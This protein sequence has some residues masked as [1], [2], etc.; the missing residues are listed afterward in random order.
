MNKRRRYDGYGGCCLTRHWTLILSDVAIRLQTA[1]MIGI[2][3]PAAVVPGPGYKVGISH[4]LKPVHA[5][6]GQKA[7]EA[8]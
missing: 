6:R 8:D 1:P 3:N 2:V 4:D 7:C 5:G